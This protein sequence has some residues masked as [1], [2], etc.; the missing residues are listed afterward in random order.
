MTRASKIA[1]THQ[2]SLG[3][4]VVHVWLWSSHRSLSKAR[5]SHNLEVKLT[6]LRSSSPS[7]AKIYQKCSINES[8][9]WMYNKRNT[10]MFE[11]WIVVF[12]GI[13]AFL[14]PNIWYRPR[15]RGLEF[16]RRY[17]VTRFC[18]PRPLV[19]D[20]NAFVEFANTVD[21]TGNV[22]EVLVVMAV[23]TAF[24][25]VPRFSQ[26][27][28]LQLE[29][30]EIPAWKHSQYLQKANTKGAYWNGHDRTNTGNRRSGFFVP[31]LHPLLFTAWLL[32][33][34]ASQ[35]FSVFGIYF[36]F[37]GAGVPF[38]DA[39]DRLL[40]LLFKC[41]SIFAVRA[42]AAPAVNKRRETFAIPES[43]GW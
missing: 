12:F 19:L 22:E 42:V 29:P 40:S 32:A 41:C 15:S 1:D 31:C 3:W 39:F 26:R 35:M 18:L 43:V 17:V 21:C 36:G 34:T 28:H 13:F 38:S 37:E 2:H 20:E 24:E 4:Y 27:E 14:T 6:R 9:W 11:T 10:W 23:V 33:V 5:R 8:I 16:R 30:H 25:D 7:I